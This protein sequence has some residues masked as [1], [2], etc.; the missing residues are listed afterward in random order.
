MKTRKEAVEF[1]LTFNNAFEDHPFRDDNWTLMRH[2]ENKKSFA[3]IYERQGK[4]W[5]NIKLIPD[6]AYFYRNAFPS[7]I[8]AYHMNKEHW[9]SIILDGSVPEN[10]IKQMISESYELTLPMIKKRKQYAKS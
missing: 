10:E 7:V 8:P 9:S 3:T 6:A 2:K 1:C 4:I 5:I